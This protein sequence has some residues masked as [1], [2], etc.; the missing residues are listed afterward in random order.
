M[1]RPI[2]LQWSKCVV[3][4]IFLNFHP[5]SENVEYDVIVHYTVFSTLRTYEPPK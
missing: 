4:S 2:S 3:F 5:L 1:G